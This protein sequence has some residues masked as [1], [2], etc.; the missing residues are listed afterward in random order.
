MHL[1]GD[2]SAR[3]LKVSLRQWPL[4]ILHTHCRPQCVPTGK[5]WI[6]GSLKTTIER[7]SHCTTDDSHGWQLW[8]KYSSFWCSSYFV[9]KICC[10]FVWWVLLPYLLCNLDTV[11]NCRQTVQQHLANMLE[12]CTVLP[13]ISRCLLK[14]TLTN[15]AVVD[16]YYCSCDGFQLLCCS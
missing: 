3:L 16:H 14:A 10:I 8:I 15:Q 6:S 11:C 12:A 2:L 1:N 5:V 13:A 9:F 7:C 4:H